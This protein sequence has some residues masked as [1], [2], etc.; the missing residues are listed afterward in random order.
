MFTRAVMQELGG[1]NLSLYG[2]EPRLAKSL[3]RRI[4][5]LSGD[6]V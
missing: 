4:S 6:P 5:K 3:D 1:I 2:W